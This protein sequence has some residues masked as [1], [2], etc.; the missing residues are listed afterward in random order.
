[1]DVHH[2]F[3]SDFI[4]KSRNKCEFSEY[5]INGKDSFC[6]AFWL[7]PDYLAIGRKDPNLVVKHSFIKKDKKKLKLDNNVICKPENEEH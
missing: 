2:Q 4:N 1:M 5:K 6:A 3:L 7:Y